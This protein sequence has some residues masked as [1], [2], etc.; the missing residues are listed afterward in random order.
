[1]YP[2]ST[3]DVSNVTV[4][5]F[6]RPAGKLNPIFSNFSRKARPP[7]FD[8]ALKQKKQLT[9]RFNVVDNVNYTSD[10]TFIYEPF[11]SRCGDFL[12]GWLQH[13]VRV[14]F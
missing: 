12:S 10:L 2:P 1:M 5:A 6:L 13:I 11:Y 9:V 3:R 8:L 4:A 14:C 7:F